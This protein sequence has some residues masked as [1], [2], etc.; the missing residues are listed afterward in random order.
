MKPVTI[1]VIVGLLLI[2]VITTIWFIT[3]PKV[4]PAPVCATLNPLYLGEWELDGIRYTIKTPTGC[5][6]RISQSP[7]PVGNA[8][9]FLYSDLD[10]T[11]VSTNSIKLGDGSTITFTSPTSAEYKNKTMKRPSPECG[12]PLD[13]IYLGTWYIWGSPIVVNPPTVCSGIITNIVGD[14]FNYTIIDSKT[15]RSTDK[16]GTIYTIEFLSKD[17][18]KMKSTQSGQEATIEFGRTRG[19]INFSS[20]TAGPSWYYPITNVPVPI[21]YSPST[22]ISVPS[23]ITPGPA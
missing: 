14:P 18:A 16:D 1:A 9:T 20:S 21:G 4:A 13:P 6:G 12:I 7:S 22:R 3:R 10:Y 5:T 2:L 15:I 17:A 19:S 11:V 23:T 8:I